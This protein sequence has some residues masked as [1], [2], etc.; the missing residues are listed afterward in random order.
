[1]KTRTVIEREGELLGPVDWSHDFESDQYFGGYCGRDKAEH[2]A[3]IVGWLRTLSENQEGYRASTY[4]GWPRIF[5]DVIHVGMYDGW[6]HWKP[7]PSVG[8]YSRVLGVIEWQ[9]FYA[10]TGIEK[11]AEQR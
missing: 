5:Q 11:K 3:K 8:L 10:L 7:T 9:P 2:I 4:G 6:P 1:M